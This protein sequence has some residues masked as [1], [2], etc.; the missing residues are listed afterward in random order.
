MHNHSD[1]CGARF[2]KQAD[3]ISIPFSASSLGPRNGAAALDMASAAVHVTTGDKTVDFQSGVT[4]FDPNL[5]ANHT[6]SLKC[7]LLLENVRYALQPPA[8]ATPSSS[9]E[10]PAWGVALI[11]VFGV[12][13][14]VCFAF[15]LTMFLRE[16]AGKPIF[17]NLEEPKKESTAP[18]TNDVKVS[19]QA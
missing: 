19:T 10:L 6:A 5:L 16:R 18:K 17:Q 4:F 14:F 8:D 2:V 13:F 9:D 15:A 1:F 11:A 12:L 7:P 3:Y